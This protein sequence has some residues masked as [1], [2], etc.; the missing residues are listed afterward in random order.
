MTDH[1]SDCIRMTEDIVRKHVV[2]NEKVIEALMVDL[3]KVIGEYAIAEIKEL[4]L[5]TSELLSEALRGKKQ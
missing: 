2:G 4:N 3:V 1:F 5:R